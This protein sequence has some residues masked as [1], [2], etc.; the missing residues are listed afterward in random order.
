MAFWLKGTGVL[1]ELTISVIWVGNGSSR[2][3]CNVCKLYQAMDVMS[4]KTEII[5]VVIVVRT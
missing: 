4:Q 2:F 1:E 3:L 5:F